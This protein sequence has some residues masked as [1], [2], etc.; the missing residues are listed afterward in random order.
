MRNLKIAV[1]LAS[2]L[3]SAAAFALNAMVQ[4]EVK[5]IDAAAAKITLKHGPIKNL[6][7]DAMTMVLRVNDPDMLKNLKVGDKVKFEA[8]RASEGVTI[9]K[10]QKSK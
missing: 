5:K 1:V 4:G 2:M 9:T 7:M 3:T 8:E 6:E 10:M